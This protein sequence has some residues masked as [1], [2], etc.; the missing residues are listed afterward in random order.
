MVFTLRHQQPVLCQILSDHKPAF[1]G[2]AAAD[3]QA[4]SLSHRIVHQA[5][6]M[7]D[8]FS[9]R[10]HHVSGLSRQIGAEEL[11]EVALPDKAYPGGILLM[12]YRQ[13]VRLRIG[14]HFRLRHAAHRKHCLSELLCMHHIQEITLILP[15]VHTPEQPAFPV[16]SDKMPRGHAVSA[17][18][19][20][21]IQK[22]LELDFPVTQHIRIRRSACLVFL[23]K[24]AEHPVPVFP[25]KVDRIV[26]NADQITH[27]AHVRPV[28]LCTAHPV[29]VGLF[30][31]LHK[32]ADDVVSLLLEHERRDR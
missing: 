11:F 6:M 8:H 24:I 12:T 4:S 32:H 18:L 10:A 26:G 22:S 29:F 21:K 30:P 3:T 14:A 13:T 19:H 7:P 20:G 15:R 1:P 28:F 2:S 5:V 31:V 17:Q 25:G 9:F 23:E 27:R 16:G